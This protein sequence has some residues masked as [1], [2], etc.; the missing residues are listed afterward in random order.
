M[1]PDPSRIGRTLPA[2]GLAFGLS[3][4][5][6]SGLIS[7]LAAC[8]ADSEGAGWTRSHSLTVTRGDLQDI[9]LMTGKLAAVRSQSLEV[10]RTSAGRLSIRF[11]VDDGARVE[12]GQVVLEFD[13]ADLA[14]QLEERKLSALEA[15]N[16]LIREQANNRALEADKAFT[17]LDTRILLDKA[18]ISAEVPASLLPEREYQDR[19][20]LHKRTGVQLAK[21]EDALR[22]HEQG[23]A[24]AMD[25]ERIALQKTK[26]EIAAAERELES[27]SLTAPTDGILIVNE[28]PWEGRKLMV[29]DNIWP[30]YAVVELPDLSVMEV[31]ARLSDVDDGRIAV[32]MPAACVLDA[33]SEQSFACRIE[34]LSPVAQSES[35]ES[36]RR[37]FVVKLSLERTDAARMRPGMSVKVQV[38]ARGAKD[39]LIAPRAGLDVIRSRAYLAEGGTTDVTIDWCTPQACVISAGLTEGVRLRAGGDA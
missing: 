29:G 14:S 21:V 23:S 34:E 1:R 15:E 22:A 33:F 2:R 7:G 32:G 3:F 18:T 4:G 37:A 38:Q 16:K 31:E 20:L 5:L 10:P 17:V 26:R 11:M 24:L 35:Q 36:M 12:K 25:I 8:S 19:Q 30:G 27:L 9:V 39:A 13:T 6:I 28:H